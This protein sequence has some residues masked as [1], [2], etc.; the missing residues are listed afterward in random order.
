ML[1]PG[2]NG[3]GTVVFCPATPPSPRLPFTCPLPACLLPHTPCLW[4]RRM[5]ACSACLLHLPTVPCLTYHIMLEE[6][7]LLFDLLPPFI[8][9]FQDPFA[10]PSHPCHYLPCLPPVPSSGRR[11]REGD[12]RGGEEDYAFILPPPLPHTHWLTFPPQPLAPFSVPYYPMPSQVVLPWGEGLGEVLPHL[13]VPGPACACS[14]P[15]SLI[16]PTRHETNLLCIYRGKGE[17]REGG[18][19]YAFCGVIY[20]PL[21]EPPTIL[22]WLDSGGG[23]GRRTLTLPHLGYLTPSHL[24]ACL[25]TCHPCMC[26]PG[27]RRRYLL[28]HYLLLTPSDNL[29]PETGR[30]YRGGGGGAFSGGGIPTQFSVTGGTHTLPEPASHHLPA[31]PIP[32]SDLPSLA[33]LPLFSNSYPTPLP[34]S[35]V[36]ALPILPA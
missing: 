9:Y 22:Y 34:G 4:R 36:C 17:G 32:Q 1:L 30:N 24:P 12:R 29:L 5:P 6:K 23:G 2:R 14:P 33:I 26:V 10:Y 11:R 3:G 27:R 28:P 25:P 21:H 20:M 16:L 13:T 18:R 7:G 31:P 19:G 15:F 35:L 8:A